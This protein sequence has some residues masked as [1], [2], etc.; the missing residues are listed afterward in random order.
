MAQ[1]KP[2]TI[3]TNI[4]IIFSVVLLMPLFL[5][6][7]SL[8]I[9]TEPLNSDFTELL[10]LVMV[11]LVVIML[12]ICIFISKNILKKIN[13]D[14]NTIE[15]LNK[16]QS[17]IFI[18]MAGCIGCAN[19]GAIVFLMTGNI[20]SLIVAILCTLA[21]LIILPSTKYITRKTGLKRDE[22]FQ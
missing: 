16:F 1:L 21:S 3:I 8:V 15:K 22:I 20:P 11:G 4:R 17:S 5:I 7:T 9:I 2:K 14:D 6:S 18:F 19:F 10:F 12:P 13:S